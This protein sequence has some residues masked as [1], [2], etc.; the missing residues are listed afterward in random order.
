MLLNLNIV[1]SEIPFIV[2]AKTCGCK[3]K[4]SISYHFIESSHS[5]CLDKREL[6]L[7][8]IQA[9]ER[10]LKYSRDELELTTIKEEITELKLALDLLHY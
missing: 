8:Q 7:A 10:L 2:E 5:L 3:N 1:E 4:K 6:V 9:C